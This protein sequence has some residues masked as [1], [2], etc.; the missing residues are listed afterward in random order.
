ML[1]NFHSIVAEFRAAW[2]EGKRPSVAEFL[3]RAPNEARDDLLQCLLPIDIEHR[4]RAGDSVITNDYFALGQ[5]AVHLANT[6]LGNIDSATRRS[7]RVSGPTSEPESKQIGP[8]RLLQKIGEGG[9]GTVWMAEQDEPVRRRVA[10]KLIRGDIGSSDAISRFEAERQALA[11][12]DHH[13]IARVLD[14]GTT[15]SGNPYFVMELVTGATITQY[16]D[17]NR[18]SIRDRLQLLI[19]VCKAV[20]H[21]HQKG[22]IHRD[23]KPSNVLITLSEGEPVAKVIDFGLAKALKTQTQLTDRTLFTQ[24]GQ[25]VGTVQYMSP[26]QA[27]MNSLDVDTRTDIYSLGV[28]L[29]ELLTGTTP[30]D[31]A[32]V[33]RKGL[34]Q[35]LRIIREQDPPRPSHRLSASGDAVTVIGEQRRIEPSKLQQILRGELDWIV[36][37]SLEKDR[38][39]RY[40][41]ANSLADDLQRYLNDEAIEARPPSTAYRIGKFVRKNRA[42]VGVVGGVTASLLVGLVGTI[43]FAIEANDQRKRAELEQ[44]IS[45]SA[46]AGERIAKQNAEENLAVAQAQRQRADQAYQHARDAVD[47][48]FTKVSESQLANIP[49][50][51]GLRQELLNDAGKYYEQFLEMHQDDPDTLVELAAARFRIAQIN[52]GRDINSAS[53]A[54]M[55]INAGLDILDQLLAADLEPDSW[56]SFDEGIYRGRLRSDPDDEG[57]RLP[58]IVAMLI[59]PTAVRACE[60]WEELVRRNPNSAGMKNDLAG[61]YNARGLMQHSAQQ[62]RPAIASYKQAIKLW[63]ELLQLDRENVNYQMDLA[64]AHANIGFVHITNGDTGKAIESHQTTFEIQ[65]KLADSENAKVI[66]SIDLAGT[67]RILGMLYEQSEQP[68]RAVQHYEESAQVMRRYLSSS[69][70]QARLLEDI[71]A[72]MD[73]LS[74][75]SST[76]KLGKSAERRDE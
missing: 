19:S 73:R 65:K 5:A 16:C 42:V 71:Q 56:G 51:Q 45:A 13:N 35:V 22:I 33:G 61:L 3:G 68:E 21:A 14:A 55:S 18:L 11:M 44:Q 74:T 17:R 34:D 1:P 28:M 60:N 7:G 69:D 66:V 15:D 76:N 27:Q 41:T 8:Y 48:F 9:M 24:F 52:V 49:A 70:N 23:L 47:E 40:E 62:T 4:I 29:F 67:L 32:T 50:A 6:K 26:E 59:L 64:L 39:R 30:L 75:E 58:T 10:V 63:E 43:W 54:V 46:L 53:K 57:G 38:A 31:K 20:Q 72:R 36:M 37:K 12:M 25:I 2:S